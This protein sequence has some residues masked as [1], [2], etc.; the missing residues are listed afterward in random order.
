MVQQL[1]D[2]GLI[3]CGGFVGNLLLRGTG[4]ASAVLAGS[5]DVPVGASLDDILAQ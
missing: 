4:Q 2:Q 5:Y 3:R 1:A